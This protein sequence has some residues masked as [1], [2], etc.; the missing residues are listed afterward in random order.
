MYRFPIGRSMYHQPHNSITA[1]S[2]H[3]TKQSQFHHH[4]SQEPGD[5]ILSPF[6]YPRSRYF[7][8]PL[9]R[10]ALHFEKMVVFACSTDSKEVKQ[11]CL[12]QI[13]RSQLRQKY[14]RFWLPPG[15]C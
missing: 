4:L 6:F 10:L 11:T 14:I 9:T 15:K 5:D 7:H 8:P 12:V 1:V 13:L 3:H 2:L